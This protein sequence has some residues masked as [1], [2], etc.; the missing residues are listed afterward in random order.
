MILP[1]KKQQ[2]VRLPS[3]DSCLIILQS[4]LLVHCPL[5]WHSCL[6]VDPCTG[7]SASPY[8]GSLHP[9]HYIPI[10][11]LPGHCQK[12]LKASL[13]QQ[14]S[15]QAYSEQQSA[16]SMLCISCSCLIICQAMCW[17]R[18][19]RQC[20]PITCQAICWVMDTGKKKATVM[21]K[22]PQSWSELL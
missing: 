22:S 16:R 2:F 18:E 3:L 12:G 7:P 9:S 20:K 1:H 4:V 8:P 13:S 14:D 10:W 11:S 5:F 15:C 21:L 19:T 6:P 17:V